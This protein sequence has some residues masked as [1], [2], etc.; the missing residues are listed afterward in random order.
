MKKQGSLQWMIVCLHF[1]T[2]KMEY[3][4]NDILVETPEFHLLYRFKLEVVVYMI[5][6][7]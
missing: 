5:Q 4:H 1:S 3:F 7:I 2:S 6:S